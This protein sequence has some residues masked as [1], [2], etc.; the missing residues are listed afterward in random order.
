MLVV[1]CVPTVS[2]VT[3][4]PRPLKYFPQK[5][6]TMTAVYTFHTFLVFSN[7]VFLFVEYTIGIFHS[8][9]AAFGFSVLLNRYVKIQLTTFT[10]LGVYFTGVGYYAVT[11]SCGFHF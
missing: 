8:D 1:P 2:P 11:S 10:V 7:L 3:F 6:I 5:S 4:H 9:G